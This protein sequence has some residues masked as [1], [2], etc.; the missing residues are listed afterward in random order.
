MRGSVGDLTDAL[1]AVGDVGIVG[2]MTSDG[3][4]SSSWMLKLS[5]PEIVLRDGPEDLIA[6][7]RISGAEFGTPKA[8]PPPTELSIFNGFLFIVFLE[9]KSGAT[10]PSTSSNK[11]DV[12]VSLLI[13]RSISSAPGVW[14]PIEFPSS[15]SSFDVS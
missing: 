2:A 12:T 14:S 8:L 15:F 11:Q 13:L 7:D 10:P 5:T 3:W 6:A 1:S 4:D 9:K